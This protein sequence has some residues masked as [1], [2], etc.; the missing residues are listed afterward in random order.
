MVRVLH[1]MKIEN[2]GTNSQNQAPIQ[3]NF[4]ARSK[5]QMKLSPTGNAEMI[6]SNFRV[7]S[8]SRLKALGLILFALILLFKGGV[9][10]SLQSIA[11]INAQLH[12]HILLT[13]PKPF[14]P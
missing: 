14:F 10:Q 6:V 11:L 4:L 5:T 2:P 3:N 13:H 12:H 9:N 7:M 8:L 1:D